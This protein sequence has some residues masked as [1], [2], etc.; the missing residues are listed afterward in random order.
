MKYKY[1]VEEYTQ[2]SRHYTVESNVK[3]TDEQ[4]T[5]AFCEVSLVDNAT[6]NL[7]IADIDDEE[8]LTGN[9]KVKVTFKYTEYGD[10]SQVEITEEQE[11]EE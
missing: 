11:S 8:Y 7:T 4:I 2:D 5:K 3:L 6:T 9:E 1:N 10:D